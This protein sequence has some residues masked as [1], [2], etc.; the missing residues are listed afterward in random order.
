MDTMSI[1][2]TDVAPCRKRVT[3]EIPADH[4]DRLFDETY[5]TIRQQVEVKG[6]RKGRAPRRALE[7]RFADEVARDV[8]SRL[9][10][11]VLGEGLRE[12]NLTP[13][14]EP[15]LENSESLEAR[16]GEAFR[17]E[18][19]LD[20]RPDFELPEYKGLAI[21]DPVAA[22]S[23]EE[24]Q[25]QLQRLADYFKD[26]QV[27]LTPAEEGDVLEADVS[28]SAGGETLFEE[29]DQ[30][31]GVEGTQLFGIEVDHL[32]DRLAGAE[33][34]GQILLT[35]TLPDDYPREE[36][37]GAEAEVRLSVKKV[38]RPVLPPVDDELAKKLGMDDLAALRRQIET[39]LEG[40]KR[41]EARKAMESELADRLL[42]EVDFELPE[43]FLRKQVEQNEARAKMRLA[44]MGA[45]ADFLKEKEEELKERA[46]TE[47]ER[48]IRRTIVYDAIAERENIE[49][50][51]AEIR[52]HLDALARHHQTTPAK[53]LERIQELNGLP[54]M[55]AEIRD[56]KVTQL[57]LDHAEITKA[58]PT[59]P[60]DASRQ[61]EQ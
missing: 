41:A 23:E 43:A 15:D 44:Q 30:R 8:R 11:E 27:K 56:M 35:L 24:V 17:F 34:G 42:A 61:E 48:E 5:D 47:T 40:E 39:N 28:F 25:E 37:R 20:V 52:A 29:A 59:E 2:V 55:A 26:H 1:D 18:A 46:A 54:A 33:P 21:T 16:P 3:V 51:E 12:K 36:L 58:T 6:F 14:G 50:E 22:P 53:M 4:V 32:V 7:K 57:L 45:N 10:Q 38:L 49:V 19:E 9:M 60:D 13:L 31:V